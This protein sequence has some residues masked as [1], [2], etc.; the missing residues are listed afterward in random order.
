[1]SSSATITAARVVPSRSWEVLQ[2]TVYVTIGGEERELFK[3]YDDELSFS[4]GEFLGL[5]QEQAHDLFHRRD[6]AYLRS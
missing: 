5:T 6:V 1:M 4:A 2:A 3:Y